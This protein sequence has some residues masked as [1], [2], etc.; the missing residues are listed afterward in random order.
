M[1]ALQRLGFEC[2]L[3][4]INLTVL[5]ANAPAGVT[6]KAAVSGGGEINT[7]NDTA[8]DPATIVQTVQVTVTT[9]LS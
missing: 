5:V 8:N 2:R 3:S 6:N 9:S 4:P 7:S 1:H